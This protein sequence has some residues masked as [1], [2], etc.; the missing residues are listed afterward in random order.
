MRTLI[1]ISTML[2]FHSILSA[3]T[4]FIHCPLDSAV[5][6]NLRQN[7]ICEDS[8][9]NRKHIPVNYSMFAHAQFQHEHCAML[10]CALYFDQLLACGL[11]LC[12]NPAWESPKILDFFKE[13]SLEE[14]EAEFRFQER[15][16]LLCDF[17]KMQECYIRINLMHYHGNLKED[18]DKMFN[19]RTF[20][21]PLELRRILLGEYWYIDD[22]YLEARPRGTIWRR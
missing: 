1:F 21:Y 9:Y 10:A 14:K 12:F 2:H 22:E 8:N 17:V 11:D 5:L 6:A 16:G 7:L 19:Q 20:R 18:I 3:Q 4:S 15:F 13:L